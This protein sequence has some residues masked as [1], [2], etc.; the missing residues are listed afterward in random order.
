MR[1]KYNL[2]TLPPSLAGLEDYEMDEHAIPGIMMN[3]DRLEFGE[4]Q[5]SLN[6]PPPSI[7]NHPP[8]EPALNSLGVIPGLD[9][10][11]SIVRDKKIQHNK[12][13]PRIIQE[14]S[15]PEVNEDLMYGTTAHDPKSI[16]TCVQDIISKMIH[17][18]PGVV[19]LE[20]VKPEKIEVYGKEIDV[21]RKFKSF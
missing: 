2:N 6:E 18:L 12:P 9:L 1:D 4:P 17:Q 8:P 3:E 13:P 16:L 20:D 11:V 7:V 21:K 14:N 5:M 10:D 19:P 15:N